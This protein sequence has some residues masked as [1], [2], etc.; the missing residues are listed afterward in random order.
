MFP[1]NKYRFGLVLALL[2]AFL[3]G[4]A[5][6]RLWETEAQIE[7]RYGRPLPSGFDRTY[8]YAF[9]NLAI[10]VQFSNGVSDEESYGLL[11]SKNAL[12]EPEIRSILQANSN[13]SQWRQEKENSWSLDGS[14]GRAYADFFANSQPAKLHLYTQDSVKRMF[15]PG[16]RAY[17]RTG[18]EQDLQGVVTVKPEA[19]YTSLVLQTDE[20]VVEIPWTGERFFPGRPHLVSGQTYTVT[21]RDE[22]GL[23]SATPSRS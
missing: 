23:D 10:L 9:E 11:D 4:R 8:F 15:E 21:L 7:G 18:K 20:L 13:G 16:L 19:T 6:A 1:M 5:S 17:P 3:P 2:V 22:S 14:H 12:T